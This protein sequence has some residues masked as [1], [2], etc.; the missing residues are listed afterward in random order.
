[1][2]LFEMTVIEMLHSRK[3]AKMVWKKKK[4]VSMG[5]TRRNSQL[6]NNRGVNYLG[7]R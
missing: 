7:N 5:E 6:R 2:G 3:K 4:K 1:M